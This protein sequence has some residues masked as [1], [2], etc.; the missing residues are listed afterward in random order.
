MKSKQTATIAEAEQPNSDLQP[1]AD[2]LDCSFCGNVL[3]TSLSLELLK[4][5]KVG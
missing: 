3:P 2:A 1:D 4:L 5:W